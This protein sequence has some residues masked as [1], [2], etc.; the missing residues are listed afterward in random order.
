ML[1][2]LNKRYYELFAQLYTNRAFLSRKQHEY[3]SDAIFQALKREL[4]EL[5]EKQALETARQT[6]ELRF[7]GR[8]YLPRGAGIFKN[9]V[10]KEYTKIFVADFQ[11][12]L[13]SIRA[14]ATPAAAPE[15]PVTAL[16][17]AT[18]EGGDHADGC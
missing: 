16:L 8:K 18:S 12:H 10:A 9:K 7:K 14:S 17:P 3:V 15:A 13:E 11:R 5:V 4:K 2:Q 1:E 6:Y